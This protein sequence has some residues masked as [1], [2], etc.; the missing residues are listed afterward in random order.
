[1]LTSRLSLALVLLVAAVPADAA[2][3]TATLR[4]LTNHL[5]YET[6]GSKKFVVEVDQDLTSPSFQVV[7]EQWR[8]VLAG[9]PGKFEKVDN[10]KRWRFWRGDFTSLEKPGTY[11]IR[12]AGPRGD[13]YSEAFAIRD[14]LLSEAC[15][16]DLINYFRSQRA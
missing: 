15:I 11:R 9:V 12:V 10:W 14:R 7:D 5:G 2:P 13:V 6:K 4:I 8:V 16:T 1:M 3:S